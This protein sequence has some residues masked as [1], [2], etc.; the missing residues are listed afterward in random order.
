MAGKNIVLCSD[1]TG[2]AGGKGRGTNVWQLFLAVDQHGHERHGDERDEREEREQLAFYDDG[3]GTS[4]FRPKQLLGLALGY[5]L[6][7][8]IRELYTALARNYDPGNDSIFLFGFSRGAF[9]VR[10]LAGMIDKVGVIDGP[11]GCQSHFGVG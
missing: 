11:H 5:G 10:S 3:V 6:G 1:G 2:N 9:T 4:S 8:N 7:A